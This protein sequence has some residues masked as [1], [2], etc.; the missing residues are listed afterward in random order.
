MERDR[1]AIMEH[2]TGVVPGAFDD[3]HPEER[4]QLYKMLSLEVL[5][6][7]D[8]S[9]EVSCALVGGR[10]IDGGGPNGAGPNGGGLGAWGPTQTRESQNT[11]PPGLRFRAL[12]TEDGNRRVQLYGV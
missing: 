2:Y 6:Y 8:K 3:L 5:A 11:Q 10:G 9:L 7:P 12:L 1:D 4:H